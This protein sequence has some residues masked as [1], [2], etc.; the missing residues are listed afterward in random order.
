[1]SRILNDP[2]PSGMSSEKAC[3]TC[4]EPLSVCVCDGDVC[5]YCGVPL[6][7]V[8][9]PNIKELCLDCA[10]EVAS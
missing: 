7:E 2:M 8:R 3:G 5:E 6:D 9:S 10:D 4:E 1:M